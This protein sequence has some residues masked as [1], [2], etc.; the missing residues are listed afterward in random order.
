MGRVK[1]FK[2]PSNDQIVMQ[3]PAVMV[4]EMRACAR[5]AGPH[6]ACGLIFG[7]KRQEKYRGAPRVVYSATRLDC[8]PSS[9]LDWSSFEI[10]YEVLLPHMRGAAEDG[11]KLVGIFH[12]HPME[13]R[14]SGVDVAYIKNMHAHPNYRFSVWVILGDHDA[15]AA[16][17]LFRGEIQRV[18]LEL[19]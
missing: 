15:L 9:Q 3:V 6:E 11:L 18:Q 19:V 2:G 4:D 8:I 7:S 12:S 13:A 1:G 5:A 10:D 17:I 14:P 16:Y